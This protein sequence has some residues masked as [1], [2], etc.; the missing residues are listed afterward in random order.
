MTVRATSRQRVASSTN[1]TWS[2][3][4]GSAPRSI[5]SKPREVIVSSASA[6]GWCRKLIVEQPRRAWKGR[7]GADP[8]DF[9]GVMTTTLNG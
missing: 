4:P 2:H 6:S 3:T 5:S 8:R 1:G 9:G 7:H